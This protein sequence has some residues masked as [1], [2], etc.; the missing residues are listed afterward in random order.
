MKLQID[1]F[2]GAGLRDY[3]AAID[4]TRVP[5]VARLQNKPYEMRISLVASTPDFVVPAAGAR[6]LIGKTNGQDVF[7]G[8]LKQPP[9]FEYLGWGEQGPVYRYDLLV[10]SDEIKP[11]QKRLPNDYPFANRSAGDALRQLT[12]D[13]AGTSIDTSGVQGL[14]K[15]AGYAPDPQKTWSQH[16]AEIAIQARASYRLENAALSLAPLGQNAY[17]L[18]QTDPDFSPDTLR[19]K[20]ADGLINDV[21]VIGEMEPQDYVKDYFV[22]DGLTGKFYLSQNPFLKTSKTL[23]DEEYSA[24]PL[25]PAS[26]VVTDPGGAVSVGGGKLQITGGTGVDGAT[27]VQFIE[28]AELGGALI[29]RHGDVMLNAPSS[30]VIGGLYAGGISIPGCL[31][32]FLITPNGSQSNIQALVN[33]V[34]T[35]PVMTTVSGHHYVFTT[36]IYSR[37]IFR[38]Q[39][40]FHSSVHAAGAGL[41][42]A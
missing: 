22:G 40:T 3:T 20:A 16:A 2:D 31:A 26:W 21:T 37:E 11:N 1:N 27:T 8:Y 4:G 33:G 30:G 15:F 39:Q 14:D 42:G 29:L 19:L 23:L 7:S 13:L 17:T 18:S 24:A 12:Q 35:G 28:Q 25:D 41:G 5:Q 36:R 38:R 9:A 6:V 32:G 10:E 34:S